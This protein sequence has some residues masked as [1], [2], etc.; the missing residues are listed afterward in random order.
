MTEK[1]VHTHHGKTSKDIL[2]ANEVLNA[3][4]L[5]NGDNFLDAGC[6]DGYISIEASNLVGENGRI[7]AFDIYPESI[8]IVKNKIKAEKLNNIEATTVDITETIPL[9]DNS[10]DLVLMANVLH[11]FVEEGQVKKVIKNI[12]RVLKPGGVFSVVE[13]RKVEGNIGPPL[14][15]KISPDNVSIILKHCGFDIGEIKLIGNYHYIVN[16]IKKL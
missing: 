11:G 8:E 4:S 7:Y 16:G 2:D 14:D 15:I 12:F 10:I 6:G 3:A 5:K 9:D 1:H 13:F